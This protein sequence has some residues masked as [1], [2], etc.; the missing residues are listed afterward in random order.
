MSPV[1]CDS[2]PS[3]AWLRA[4]SSFAPGLAVELAARRVRMARALPWLANA[5][6][7]LP[8]FARLGEPC[9]SPT[10]S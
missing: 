8:R 2:S 6:T 1:T 4:S 10:F 7:K 5:P 3:A 9:T